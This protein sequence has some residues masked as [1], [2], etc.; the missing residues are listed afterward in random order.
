MA[1]N[2]SHPWLSFSLGPLE[3][4]RNLWLLLGEVKSKCEHLANEILEP[5]TAK[6]LHKFYLAKGA[7]AT[8]AIEGNTLTEVEALEKVEG[9]LELP[10][11]QEYLGQEIQNI[12]TA[13]NAALNVVMKR[14]LQFPLHEKTVK[15]FNELILTGLALSEKVVIGEIRT[16]EVAVAN[17]YQ[18]PR[19]DECQELLNKM[20]DWLNSDEFAVPADQPRMAI[21]LAT[22]KAVLA[23]LYIAWIHP[24]G[25]GNGRTARL[26]EFAILVSSGV[27]SPAA[28]LMSNH[29]NLTRT[30]YYRRLREAVMPGGDIQFI[31]YAVQGFVDGLHAQLQQVRKQQWQLAWRNYVHNLL[32]EGVTKTDRQRR[33]VLDLADRTEGLPLNKLSEASPRVAL[34]YA[35]TSS[36]TLVRDVA[37]LQSLGL[38]IESN[39]GN[40]KANKDI[41]LGMR[42]FTVPYQKSPAIDLGP[43]E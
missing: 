36:K 17:A 32:P 2:I 25:D 13:C 3:T 16:H 8:N 35:R 18:A 11:S 22:I 34:M 31:K 38:L 19:S 37:Q 14:G 6:Q 42:S 23:H 15:H 33:L 20:C 7:L 40:Y 28:H 5:E 27:P 39:D 10:P 12:I 43:K 4:H 9:T 24:F 41:V 26:V 21:P 29:Y 1:Y 30:E